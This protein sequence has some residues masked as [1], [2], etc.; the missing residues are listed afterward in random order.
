M[1]VT[2]IALIPNVR[3]ERVSSTCFPAGPILIIK[4]VLQ[5]PPK[6]SYNILVSL[7][8]LNGTNVDF[9]PVRA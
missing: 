3:L 1:L 6:A 8:S 7:E 5:F 9:G 2:F 4:A